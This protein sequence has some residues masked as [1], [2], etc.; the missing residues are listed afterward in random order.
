MS[1]SL[2]VG[3]LATVITLSSFMVR[4]IVKLRI[5][6]SLGAI[7]WIIYGFIIWQYPVIL[8]NLCILIIHTIYLIRWRKN[9]RKA[10]I[11]GDFLN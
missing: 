10:K 9:S 11:I 8:T 2:I 7:V 4:H 6:N 5:L 1:L 3:L